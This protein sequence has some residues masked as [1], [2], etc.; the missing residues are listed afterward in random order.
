MV[1]NGFVVPDTRTCR[2]SRLW[3]QYQRYAI[4]ICD[5]IH[6]GQWGLKV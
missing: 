4:C 6:L 3:H 1:L 5:K 2:Y